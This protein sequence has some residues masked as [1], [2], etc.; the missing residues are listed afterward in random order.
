MM[1]DFQCRLGEDQGARYGR[2]TVGCVMLGVLACLFAQPAASAE[3]I[4]IEDIQNTVSARICPSNLGHVREITYEQHCGPNF[5]SVSFEMQD[6]REEADQRNRDIRRYNDWMNECRQL[7]QSGQASSGSSS[8]SGSESHSGAGNHPY[9]EMT[10]L[11]MAFEIFMIT[12]TDVSKIPPEH[13]QLY[14]VYVTSKGRSDLAGT[15]QVDRQKSGSP[16][17]SECVRITSRAQGLTYFIING[18]SQ[19]VDVRYCVDTPRFHNEPPV[20]RMCYNKT[21]SPGQKFQHAIGRDQSIF[22][23]FADTGETIPYGGTDVSAKSQTQSSAPLSSS[24][25]SLSS[26]ECDQ[27]LAQIRSNRNW[28]ANAGASGTVADMVR[29]ATNKN[30]AIYNSQCR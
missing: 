3:S 17:P 7:R 5:T 6:C 23:T 2:R 19:P 8:D 16:S 12:D 28:L 27:I 26:A 25:G 4:T 22:H 14:A 15:E 18:C 20:P 10:N 9:S 30:V 21:I 13:Q 1:E 29:E 11:E 24:G